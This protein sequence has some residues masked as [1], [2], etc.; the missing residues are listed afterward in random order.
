MSYANMKLADHGLVPHYSKTVKVGDVFGRLTIVEIG[1]PPGTY[2]YKAICRCEC[3]TDSL[4]RLDGIVAGNV[5]SCG[6]YHR[7][8]N[9]QHGLSKSPLYGIWR[10]MIDRCENPNNRA[11]K[12]YGGRGISVCDRWRMLEN[13][14]ADMHA[15]YWPG[16]EIDRTNNNG[17]Y[18]PDNCD[19]VTSARNSD[20]RRSARLITFNGKTQSLKRWSEES[21]INYGTLHT[22]LTK[23][24]WSVERALTTPSIEKFERMDI[25]RTA[26]WGHKSVTTTQ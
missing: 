15:T 18:E 8:V 16:A 13:F 22:R 25:A 11:F 7:E 21:G 2:R 26:R 5:V 17:N 3:G 4:I 24:G 1:K 23:K 10:K 14:Y 12:N 9:C 20:N 19:W 6:C